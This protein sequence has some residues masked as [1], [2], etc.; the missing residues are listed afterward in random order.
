MDKHNEDQTE[1]DISERKRFTRDTKKRWLG[2]QTLNQPKM[3]GKIYI[4]LFFSFFYGLWIKILFESTEF[5]FS[6]PCYL[7]NDNPAGA[8][9]NQ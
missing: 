6:S 4:S 7:F 1:E 2:K 3:M 9:I 8:T 5:L